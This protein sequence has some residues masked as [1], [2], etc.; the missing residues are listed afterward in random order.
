MY[1]SKLVHKENKSPK[2]L[3]KTVPFSIFSSHSIAACD[4]LNSIQA[5]IGRLKS[6]IFLN[7][8]GIINVHKF[9]HDMSSVLK[10]IVLGL[11]LNRI[12]HF[13]SRFFLF[14]A[15]S[16]S[17][18]IQLNFVHKCIQGRSKSRGIQRFTNRPMNCRPQCPRLY[19]LPRYSQDL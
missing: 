4:R 3:L 16:A 11:Y 1:P 15:G 19:I 12:L 18:R 9:L 14:R 10:S 8:S 7:G 6:A 13:S 2:I 17:P 5:T